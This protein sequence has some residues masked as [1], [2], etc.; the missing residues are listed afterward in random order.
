MAS[1]LALSSMAGASSGAGP[2]NCAAP[3]AASAVLGAGGGGGGEFSLP[4]H[5]GIV[6]H[7]QQLRRRVKCQRQNGLQVRVI[8]AYAGP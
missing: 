1:W 7:Q 4:T 6:E 5:L 3:Q 2:N 8:C